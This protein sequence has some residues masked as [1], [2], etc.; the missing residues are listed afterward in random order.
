MAFNHQRRR[1]GS[2][3]FALLFFQPTNGCS[4]YPLDGS[5][6]AGAEHWLERHSSLVLVA[7]ELLGSLEECA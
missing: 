7:F 6:I 2:F 1:M 3:T 4:V 5:L